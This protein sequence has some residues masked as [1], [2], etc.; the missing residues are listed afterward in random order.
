[1]IP[2]TSFLLFGLLSYSQFWYAIPLVVSISLVYGA[3]RHERMR[4]ILE[5]SLRAAIWIAGFMLVI[6]VILFFVARTL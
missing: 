3:T 2:T 6:F 4:P 1:M 5:H